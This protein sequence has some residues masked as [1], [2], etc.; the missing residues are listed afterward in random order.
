LY[1]D[2]TNPV[3]TWTTPLDDGSTDF[4]WN[5]TSTVDLT[6]DD[7][8]LFGYE[9]LIYD[10]TWT[11]LYY[12]WT[13]TDLDVTTYNL[14]ET[15][16]FNTTG[17]Y[18]IN[19]TVSDDHTLNAIEDY[20][21]SI[22]DT[23]NKK[24]TFD[25]ENVVEYER[26]PV[27]VT[28]EYAGVRTIEDVSLTKLTD[29]YTFDYTFKDSLVAGFNDKY[30]VTCENIIFRD[31][32]DYVA[33]FVCPESKNWVDFENMNVETF[34]VK[35]LSNDSYEVELEYYNDAVREIAFNSIGGIN[36]ISEQST[37]SVSMPSPVYSFFFDFDFDNIAHVMLL[38][39]LIILFIGSYV[40]YKIY[41]NTIF[42]LMACIVGLTIG[43]VF[44]LINA[45]LGI[46]MV[47]L[48][49]LILFF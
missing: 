33:H 27:P 6:F 36:I 15:V 4:T 29:R 26:I 45:W 12:N 1:N 21:Y 41:K 38:G 20:K 9:V 2:T 16:I 34:Y 23:D 42:G 28:I 18:S 24:L 8:N 44:L 39:F 7:P 14:L 48:S 30:I 17:N 46:I 10:D 25:F 35:K 5:V 22:N 49:F 19:I 13:D 3:I 31:K 32:S 37:F 11:T 47:I 43:S 40:L